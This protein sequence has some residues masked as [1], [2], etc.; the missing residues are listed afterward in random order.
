MNSFFLLPSGEGGA[1]RRPLSAIH[2]LRGTW[3]AAHRMRV[4]VCID[5]VAEPTLTPAPLPMG[6]GF[7][8]DRG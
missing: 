8:A 7:K 2:G 1:Q 6:E 5:A 3:A 4:R